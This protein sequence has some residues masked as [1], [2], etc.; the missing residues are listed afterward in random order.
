MLTSWL[1]AVCQ[2]LLVGL[3]LLLKSMPLPTNRFV[4]VASL[5]DRA[6]TAPSFAR[7]SAEILL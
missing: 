4:L 5:A 2:T 6:R 7:F 3:E 1:V